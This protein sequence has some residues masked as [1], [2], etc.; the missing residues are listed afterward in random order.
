[1]EL[2]LKNK[3]AIVTG[4]NNPQGIGAATAFALA[5][6]GVRIALV[7]KRIPHKVDDIKTG[8]NG[9]DRYFKA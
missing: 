1:M 5:S 4:T 3:T 2:G 9:L 8:F 7:Y 6:E